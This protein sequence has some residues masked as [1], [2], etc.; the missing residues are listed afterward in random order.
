MG[1]L[2]NYFPSLNSP[3]QSIFWPKENTLLKQIM[4]VISGVVLL[5][6]SAHIII[7][8]Q[9]VPLTFQSAA[10][11]FVGMVY[12][13]RLGACTLAAYLIAGASG[14]PVFANIPNETSYFFGHTA[15]YLIGFLPACAVSGYLAQKG[16]AKHILS[17]F[18]ASCLGASIIFF[19]GI[20]V[21]S[22]FIGWHD[23]VFLGL[24]PFIVTEPIKLFVISLVIPRFW[25]NGN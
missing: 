5:A 10:V 3:L 2:M 4:L 23:A 17:S 18:I 14:L 11:I 22:K 8:L 13:A 24:M 1:Y 16:W 20:I 15:G 12:G 25:K 21:L 6:I 19:F 7:P 9:P